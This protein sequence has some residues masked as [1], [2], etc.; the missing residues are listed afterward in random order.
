MPITEYDKYTQTKKKNNL[1]FWMF[2]ARTPFQELW[3]E[4]RREPFNKLDGKAD[5]Q[6][7]KGMYGDQWSFK[8]TSIQPGGA[9]T[10][11]IFWM[12]KVFV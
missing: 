7:V 10:H 4:G 2:E 9:P 6:K 12:S 3:E 8:W 5:G 1:V 11:V